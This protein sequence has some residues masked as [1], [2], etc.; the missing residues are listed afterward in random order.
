MIDSRTVVVSLPLT[1]DRAIAPFA[2]NDPGTRSIPRRPV[3]EQSRA[4]DVGNG[5]GDFAKDDEAPEWSTG[6]G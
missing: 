5:G 1:D 6:S 4:S 3:T 2:C